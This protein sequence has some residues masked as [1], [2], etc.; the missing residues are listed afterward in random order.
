MIWLKR[1]YVFDV[2]YDAQVLFGLIR[3]QHSTLLKIIHCVVP[4][5]EY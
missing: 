5:N 1:N 2:N 3:S 4:Q